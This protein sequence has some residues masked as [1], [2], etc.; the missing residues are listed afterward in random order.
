MKF[1][2]GDVAVRFT[3][4]RAGRTITVNWKGTPTDWRLLLVGVDAV[5]DVVGGVA[6][7]SGEG[8]MQIVPAAEAAP[9]TILLPD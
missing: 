8:G 9:L 3:V 5:D 2:A 1:T 7:G 4:D 6:E